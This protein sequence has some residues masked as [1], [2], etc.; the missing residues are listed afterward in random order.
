L[1]CGRGK[2]DGNEETVMERRGVAAVASASGGSGGERMDWIC[3]WEAIVTRVFRR[4][5]RE[6]ARTFESDAG[7]VKSGGLI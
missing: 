5:K 1:G 2:K 6:N 4:E 7:T 3:I